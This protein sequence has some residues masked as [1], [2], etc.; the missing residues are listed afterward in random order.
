[1]INILIVGSG[2]LGSRHLQSLKKVKKKLNITVIDSN[3][4]SLKVAKERYDSFQENLYHH[5]ISYQT[6]FTKLNQDHEIAIIATNSDSRRK[7][8][9]D[10]LEK[11]NIKNIILE[12]IL[13]N[14][15]EDYYFIQNIFERKK[16]NAWV[17]C[18]MRSNPFYKNLKEHF[19]GS[20]LHYRVIGS[21]YGL[22]TNLIHYLDHISYLTNCTEFNLDLSNI[23][24]KII[25]SKR[26]GFYELNGTCI[27]NFQNGSIGYFTCFENGNM[28]ITVEIASD[29]YYC[30]SK[31][32]QQKAI[33]ISANKDIV[34]KEC[35]APIPYQSEMTY[36]LIENI[37]DNYYCPLVTFSESLTIHL[38][39][40][41]PLSKF[42]NN[43]GIETYS[44][45]PFT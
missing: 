25:P 22:I 12:K 44:E 13:F 36:S 21:Q 3:K 34:I 2:Q 33:I 18:S 15:L 5:N 7:V 10:L 28:P 23:S 42:L 31:E 24:G 32:F 37:L 9:H 16:I 39:M 30:L 11:I 43:N 20:R 6:D 19:D 14:K 41:K 38:N 4:K 29:S 45:F 17:N 8:I 26:S 1:M 35:D 27:A 40:L